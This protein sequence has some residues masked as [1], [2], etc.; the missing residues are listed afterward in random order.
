MN[1][2][3]KPNLFVIEGPDGCG[4]TTTIRLLTTMLQEAG[5]KPFPIRAPGGTDTG[6]HIRE[7]VI[8][9]ANSNSHAL[10]LL[11]FADF[12]LSAEQ[13]IVPAFM[14]GH[15]PI[16]DRF[17][18]STEVYQYYRY[19]KEKRDDYLF[20]LIQQEK[21]ELYIRYGIVPHYIVLTGLPL[22]VINERIETRD[23]ELT[24]F[25]R[26]MQS[27]IDGYEEAMADMDSESYTKVSLM[28]GGVAMNEKEV[29]RK[30][31]SVIDS[32]LSVL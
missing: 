3:E 29:A 27:V 16:F 32:I 22:S 6:R 5:R 31:F 12:I 14:N 19:P 18:L 10:T 20:T 21:K 4:K 1:T 26:N 17:V 25:E 13:Q 8:S 24:D 11:F 23:E 30:V 7:A 2:K 28:Q 15:I 9:A